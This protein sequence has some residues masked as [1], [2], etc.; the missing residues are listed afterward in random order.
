MQTTGFINGFGLDLKTRKTKVE[1]LL[2]SNEL[3]SLEKLNKNKILSIEI[4]KFYKKRSLDANSYCWVL[5]NEIAKS[6]STEEAVVFKEDVYRDAILH[7]GTFELMIIQ[8]K[9]LEN[10][11]RV[12]GKQGIGFIVN[13][14]SRKNKCVKVCAYYGSSTYNTNEMSRLLNALIMQAKE[15]NIE[16][17]KAK[18]VD[19]LIESW[20]KDESRL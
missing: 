5:C 1:L 12:W 7:A 14:I 17:K 2:D 3:E 11:K 13:E 9:A 6:I 16:T 15:L 18:E 10:F 4:K 19:E 8:I 20:G